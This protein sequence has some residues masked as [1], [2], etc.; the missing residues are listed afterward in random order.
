M[1]FENSSPKAIRNH[2]MRL[3]SKLDEILANTEFLRSHVSNYIGDGVALTYLTDEMPIYINSHDFGPSANFMSGGV[4]EQ[5]NLDVLMSFVRDDTVFLDIGANLGFFS[6]QIARRVRQFGKVHSFEPHPELIRLLRASSF[7][8][9]LGDVGGGGAGAIATHQCGLG[10]ENTT[11]Q[12]SYPIGFLAGGG[13]TSADIAGNTA[14]NAEIRRL[15]DYFDSNFKF[16]LAKIDVEGHE[17]EVLRGM[18]GTLGRNR[19]A[20]ILFEKIG[21]D[22]GY[23][24]EI[25][26]IFR[27]LGHSLYGVE[28]GSVLR[29]IPAG[30]LSAWDGYI[31]AAPASAIGTATTRS[32]FS[33]YP[34]QL[35][36]NSSTLES[37]DRDKLIVAGGPESLLFHGPY[38]FLRRGAYKFVIHGKVEGSVTVTFAAR[39]GTSVYRF[40]LSAGQNEMDVIVDRDLVYFECVAR[41]SSADAKVE[42][43]KIELIRLG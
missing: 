1:M 42:I 32:R 24:A 4:Y 2:F 14:I 21:T 36:V 6:L 10:D 33:V 3:E 34:R 37:L 28:S 20:K 9:G 12:F 25:E 11:V 5:E 26:T 41:S 35:S 18:L 30:G 22:R 7:L 27:G 19:D 43:E 23:E 39:F 13:V 29:E 31:L 15:D 40:D 17:I 8:N 16:D 38:W